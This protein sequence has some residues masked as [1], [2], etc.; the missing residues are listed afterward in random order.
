[1]NPLD[2]LDRLVPAH[3]R[4]ERL[5]QLAEHVPAAVTPEPYRALLV[6]DHHMTL[7]MEDFHGNPVRVHVLDRNTDEEG[8]HRTSLLT[9]P[10]STPRRTHSESTP[11]F[12][13]ERVVQFGAIRFNF[14]FVTQDV[15]EAI[16]AEQTPLGQVLIDHN[17][18]RHIDLGAVLR[19]EIGPA[20]SDIFGCPVGAETYGRLATIFC[21]R[22][23][24]VDLLEISAPLLRSAPPP[25]PD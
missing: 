2:E 6:H 16:L 5:F 13:G 1:M 9:V 17:V 3:L 25:L 10:E 23:P 12:P 11:Q 18:L 20:L 7:A 22:R 8:Y 19:I 21:N 24:A 4:H 15:R 14:E